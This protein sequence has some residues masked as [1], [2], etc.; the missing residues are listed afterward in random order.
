MAI[1]WA[2]VTALWWFSL[3]HRRYR[4]L[5]DS[6]RIR[7]KLEPDE[8]VCHLLE[9][10]VRGNTLRAESQDYDRGRYRATIVMSDDLRDTGRG[11]YTN[12]RDGERLWGFLEVQVVREDDTLHVHE[13]YISHK[14]PGSPERQAVR[15]AYVWERI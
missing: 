14:H 2:G 6:Y 5:A 9:V 11:H 10:T 13:T 8:V 7:R 1:V 4:R 15:S 12:F 3:R